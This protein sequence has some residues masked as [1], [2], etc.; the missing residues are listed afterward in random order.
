MNTGG[1][2]LNRKINIAN[3]SK[4]MYRETRENSWDVAGNNFK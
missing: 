1:E 4:E 3:D 2:R